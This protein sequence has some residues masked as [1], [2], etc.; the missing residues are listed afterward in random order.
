MQGIYT[1]IPE[2]NYVP[3]VLQLFCYYYYYYVVY[4]C[5]VTSHKDEASRKTQYECHIDSMCRERTILQWVWN[6][7]GST[8]HLAD[9]YCMALIRLQ[10]RV[11]KT[12]VQHKMNWQKRPVWD[13][14]HIHCSLFRSTPDSWD[15]VSSWASSWWHSKCEWPL[16]L[17]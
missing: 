16:I 4:R 6:G 10:I 5:Y 8:I 14:A 7:K 17:I 12:G 1:Y 3:T 11:F 2:T 15:G 9:E 13:A